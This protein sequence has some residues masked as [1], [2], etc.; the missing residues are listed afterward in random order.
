MDFLQHTHQFVYSKLQN[1]ILWAA[2]M[3]CILTGEES[4]P[5]AYYGES[6]PGKMK[7]VYRRGLGHRYGKMMQAIAGIHYNYSLSD[8]FWVWIPVI[9]EHRSLFVIS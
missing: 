6:N 1:E 2:S 5:I 3:P 9:T 4:I 7:T 8:K